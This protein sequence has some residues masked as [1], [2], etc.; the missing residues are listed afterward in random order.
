MI[1]HTGADINTLL[2]I[3]KVF[4]RDLDKMILLNFLN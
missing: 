1:R 2:C 3:S 4:M